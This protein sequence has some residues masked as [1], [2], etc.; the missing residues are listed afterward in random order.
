MPMLWAA[1]FL[2]PTVPVAA[3]CTL[4]MDCGGG[5]GVRSQSYPDRE[6]CEAGRDDVVR[7]LDR[8]GGGCDVGSCRC[9]AAPP[10]DD[11]YAPPAAD[12]AAEEEQRRAEEDVRR[13]EEEHRLQKERE[14]KEKEERFLKDREAA[15]GSLK[16]LSS[17]KGPG[18]KGASSGTPAL[19]G[20]SSAG[21]LKGVGSR[22][23]GAVDMERLARIW[24]LALDCSLSE[25]Y[26]SAD[27]LGPAG[28]AFKLRV[29]SDLRELKKNLPTVQP[30][31]SSDAYELL[32]LHRSEVLE[33]GDGSQFVVHALVSRDRASG[34][35][36]VDVSY[37][38]GKTKG[39][40]RDGRS[41]IHINRYGEIDCQEVTPA[42]AACLKRRFP[43]AADPAY[44]PRPPPTK[45][46]ENE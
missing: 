14:A 44:C 23:L 25:V 30:R 2:F 5:Y 24:S 35:T 31:D 34:R 43:A 11:S 22:P 27:A 41:V 18:V 26:E 19:K 20:L 17:G 40:A 7:Q 21:G 32:S 6:S 37:S 8:S 28:T 4:S 13:R 16:G 45:K 39:R 38:A 33:G 36:A 10:P 3:Q 12:P 1:L 15:V 46:G 9:A 42:A 29:Q